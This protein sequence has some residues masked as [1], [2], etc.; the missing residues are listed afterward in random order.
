MLG[1]SGWVGVDDFFVISGFLITLMLLG[2]AEE[3]EITLSLLS[4]YGRRAFRILPALYVYI[5]I[6]YFWYFIG[7]HRSAIGSIVVA[8]L[9][10]TD[11][12]IGYGWGYI[13][14]TG[15]LFMT[16]TL[17]VEEKFYLL[18]PLFLRIQQINRITWLCSCLIFIQI[19]KAYLILALHS[20][21]IRLSAPF[22]TK[23]DT[24]II[25]CIFALLCRNSEKAQNLKQALSSGVVQ[26]LVF[27]IL[28]TTTIC[29]GPLYN[30][31]GI[32]EKLLLWNF[33]MPMHSVSFAALI[34]V[35]FFERLV[36]LRRIL[37]TTAITWF[38]RISYSTYI[39]HV[40]V[41]GLVDRVIAPAFAIPVEAPLLEL[42]RFWLSLSVA[43]CSYYLVEFPMRR[44]GYSLFRKTNEGVQ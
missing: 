27:A 10:L 35:L 6:V 9:G 38:G 39:W 34:V 7:N 4:F 33:I 24:I 11:F 41:F 44:V 36:F 22:D 5:A 23:C 32:P 1:R 19:W 8:I 20:P 18:F 26:I 3:K 14:A 28:A 40:Y 43:S 31:E 21:W 17:C 2:D 16:W 12:D 37:E 30:N 25:G 29:A 13:K 15:H 42:I